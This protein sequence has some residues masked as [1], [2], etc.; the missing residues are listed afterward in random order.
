MKKWFF[1]G[2]SLNSLEIPTISS[3]GSYDFDILRKVTLSVFRDYVSRKAECYWTTAESILDVDSFHKILFSAWWICESTNQKKIWGW[4]LS[5]HHL[6]SRLD[7]L[8]NH[9]MSPQFLSVGYAV[10]PLPCFFL[11]N[12][13]FDNRK[14]FQNDEKYLLFHVKSSLRS[15]DI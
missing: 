3:A 9:A 10:I 2:T 8:L 6:I 14:P 7:S 1:L 12:T 11:K 4:S 5:Y 13:T 15:Q